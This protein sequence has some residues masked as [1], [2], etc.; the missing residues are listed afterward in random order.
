MLPLLVLGPA[1]ARAGHYALPYESVAGWD[2]D[3]LSQLCE[4]CA[5]HSWW[6]QLGE[7]VLSGGVD[8]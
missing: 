4:R 3:A 6:V 1:L 7:K 8:G 2:A 5:A